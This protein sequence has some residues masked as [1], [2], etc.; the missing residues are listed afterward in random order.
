MIYHNK[1]FCLLI[2]T[3]ITIEASK[4]KRNHLQFSF[5]EVQM[6]DGATEINP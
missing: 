6:H 4:T 3:I 2:I 1:V 5:A